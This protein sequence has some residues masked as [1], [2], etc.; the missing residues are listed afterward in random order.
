MIF[1]GDDTFFLK[2][3]N[4]RIKFSRDETGKV[5]GF[6]LTQNGRDFVAVLKR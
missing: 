1:V 6:V 5:A 4:I 2:I 3:Q